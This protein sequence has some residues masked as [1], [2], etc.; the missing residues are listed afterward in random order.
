MKGKISLPI[1]GNT[2]MLVH[3]IDTLAESL[4]SISEVTDANTGVI[5]TRDKVLFVRD[6]LNLS[7]VVKANCKVLTEGVREGRLYYVDKVP[8]V[9]SIHVTQSSKACLLTWHH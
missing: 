4:L 2:D 5:F 1:P 3:Q 7:S 9:S 6:D 8:P